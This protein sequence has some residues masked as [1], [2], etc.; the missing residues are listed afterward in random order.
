MDLG[1]T[2]RVALIT[3]GSSG[4][5]RATAI[6]FAAEGAKVAI[7]YRSNQ[8]AAGETALAI[9]SLGGEAM[10]ATM[11]LADEASIAAAV[12]AVLDRWGGIDVLVNNAVDSLTAA[13]GPPTPFSDIPSP[14]WQQMIRSSVE[15]A[16]FVTQAA[17]PLM[18]GRAG[19]RIVFVSSALAEYG[20]VGAAAY[21]ASKAALGGLCRSLAREVGPDGILVN[22]VMPG[23]VLTERN[24]QRLPQALLDNVSRETPSGRI[25]TPED[26]A[27]TILFLCSAANGNITGETVH[28]TGGI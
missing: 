3:G 18:L 28:I 16:F 17:L 12:T 26:V 24:L 21:G 11:D 6:A 5:G 1:L 25:S 27:S 7:T 19:V 20:Q 23:I 10:T 8:Q 4:I 2:D 15:G 14:Q 9:R 13:P 22:V